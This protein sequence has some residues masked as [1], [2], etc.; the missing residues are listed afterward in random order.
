MLQI[1][2]KKLRS[3]KLLNGCLFF[4]IV[5]LIAVFS[6]IPMFESGALDNVFEYKFEDYSEE[7]SNFPSTISRWDTYK[8]D[9]NQN[10]T[11]EAFQ[12]HVHKYINKWNEYLEL[13]IIA[14]Q[15]FYKFNAG[16]FEADL[17]S[18]EKNI[19]IGTFENIEDHMVFH[20]VETD[21]NK[22]VTENEAYPVYMSK[23]IMDELNLTIGEVL[24]LSSFS[25]E[26]NDDV[27]VKIVGYV[28]EKDPNEYFWYTK[29]RTRLY[30]L[31]VK[32]DTFEKM[33]TEHKVSGVA[34]EINVLY[35]Y[36]YITKDNIYVVV[37][38]LKQFQ[39]KDKS[40]KCK[41]LEVLR[42]YSD[43]ERNIKII[44]ISILIPLFVLLLLF[45]Y[46][47]SDRIIEAEETEI[48]VLRSRGISRYTIIKQYILQSFLV[49]LLALIPGVL[50]G[51]GLTKLG[52][53]SVSFLDFKF[54]NSPTYTLNPMVAVYATAAILIS[55][56][57]SIIPV[58]IM[59]KNT[60]I[61]NRGRNHKLTGKNF[62]EKYFLD[63]ILLGISIYLLYNYI[64]QKGIMITDILSGKMM[65]PFI[66]FNAELFIFGAAFLMI[67]LSRL[68][69]LLVF[70]L[71]KNKWKPGTLAAFLEV[72]RTRKKS[73]VIS[74]FLIL[75][76]SMGIYNANLAETVNTNKKVRLSNDIGTEIIL[77]PVYS[78]T[79]KGEDGGWVV[80][81][82]TF[83]ELK[84]MLN[85]GIA[86]NMASVY[87]TDRASA[88][89]DKGNVEKIELYSINSYQFGKSA[90]FDTTL[91]KRHWF[92][93][94]NALSQVSQGAI[95]SRDFAED[96]NLDIDS[97]FRVNIESPVVYE[98]SS[99]SAQT[100]V[101]V[102]VVAI[103]DNFPGYNGYYYEKDNKKIEEKKKYLCVVNET[104]LSLNYGDVVPEYWIDL[105]EG[106]GVD[107]IKQFLNDNN[108]E[109]SSITSYDIEIEKFF[110]SA[111]ILITNG[112]FNISFIVSMIICVIGF[113]I[114][115]LTSIRSRQM[116]FG[117][118]RAM[119][120]G[121]K[122][123]NR[124]LIKEHFFST[125]FS[126]I[127]SFI[128]GAITSKCFIDLIS[129]VYLPEKHSIPLKILVS[130]KGI[131]RI[132]ILIAIA[133][134]LCMTI[135][136]KY[137]KD[138]NITEAIK[139]GEE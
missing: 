51:Y 128:V 94:L 9:E 72:L 3:K 114:Y 134:V 13:P 136:I 122:G 104:L 18:R 138:M 112:L 19:E 62:I 60:T 58:I 109:K 49:G 33:M 97:T 11:Y 25:D 137:I 70:K 43:I 121:M 132:G 82:P 93:D 96:Y 86:D 89:T 113:L 63:I 99:K 120:L 131:I 98:D 111:V 36:R 55:V 52:A 46:M 16:R 30:T 2:R 29:Q 133:I 90:K 125:F 81:G 105:A 108:I 32:N 53:S 65:D 78:V 56:I 54:R 7:N 39:R 26:K 31:F 14:E 102:S 129:C 123:I 91:N 45:I 116:Y 77:E 84:G 8:G 71:R 10:I 27:K 37:D 115:W 61:S 20:D 5:I 47:V 40:F 24:T 107:D 50:L 57:I 48:N 92:N 59:S 1:I 79:E 41:F 35:D 75:T 38:Y 85:D 87:K 23:V 73:W 22:S 118:Y 139:M 21:I 15:L 6:V 88:S 126:V 103:V 34:Y 119:G 68:I 28:E 42:D 17:D 76:I 69:V 110:S 66:F 135:I 124:M 100:P 74:V 12:N 4:G 83:N 95:I 64:K 101:N 80:S 106:K 67:R 44:I 117:I 130:Q 127:S